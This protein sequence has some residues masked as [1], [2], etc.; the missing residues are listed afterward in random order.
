LSSPTGPRTP[1]YFAHVSQRGPVKHDQV[2][3]SIGVL[4]TLD[5]C[6]PIGEAHC[7]SWDENGLASWTIRIGNQE[8]P[9]RWVIIDREFMAM[10]GVRGRHHADP[11]SR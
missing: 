8:I 9:G 11:F 1:R 2:P 6:M 10:E 7:V 4:E 3:G 5:R